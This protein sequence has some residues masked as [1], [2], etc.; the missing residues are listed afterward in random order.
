MEVLTNHIIW[1]SVI[2]NYLHQ[3]ITWHTK[4]TI[5]VIYIS[6]MLKIN[7]IGSWKIGFDHW[8]IV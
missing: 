8:A 3:I 6:I 5:Q 4:L 2:N 7:K 1:K